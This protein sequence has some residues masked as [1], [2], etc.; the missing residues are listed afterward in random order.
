MQYRDWLRVCEF[1]RNDTEPSAL[2]LT[3]KNQQSFKW[4]ARRGEVVSNKDMPQDAAS[5]VDWYERLG[6]CYPVDEEKNLIPWTTQKIWEL[7]KRYRFRYVL[8]DRRVEGQSPPLLPLLYPKVAEENA[9]FSVFEIPA[10]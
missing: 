8:I 7:H 6:A 2:W 1:I 3:P 9:T 10:D 5:V 4:Q